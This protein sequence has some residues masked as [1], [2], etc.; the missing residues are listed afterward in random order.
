MICDELLQDPN[1]SIYREE[2]T[3]KGEIIFVKDHRPKVLLEDPFKK[4]V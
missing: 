3:A 2:R 1:S 4:T